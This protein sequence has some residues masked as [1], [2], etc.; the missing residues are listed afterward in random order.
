MLAKYLHDAASPKHTHTH[1]E[2]LT[3]AA[4]AAR[5]GGCATSLPTSLPLS[6]LPPQPTSLALNS[7]V[8][9]IEIENKNKTSWRRGPTCN[10]NIIT[11]SNRQQ[12]RQRHCNST[13]NVTVAVGSAA[14]ESGAFTLTWKAIFYHRRAVVVIYLLHCLASRIKLNKQSGT[15]EQELPTQRYSGNIWSRGWFV[16]LLPS[17]C[18]DRSIDRFI[19]RQKY[20][21]ENVSKLKRLN[22]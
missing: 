14:F 20:A 1:L 8:D 6:Q 19:Y 5:V 10:I 17:N 15:E 3:A 16:P 2:K 18:N 7:E 4:G 12:R 22:K 21:V 13:I 9:A 11:Y